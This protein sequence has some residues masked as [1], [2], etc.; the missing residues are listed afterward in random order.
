MAP[1]RTF[2]LAGATALVAVSA[3]SAAD[4]PPI[5]HKA[6]PIPVE[7]FGGWYLR[8]DVGMSNQQARSV[9][10]DFGSLAPPSSMNVISQGFDSAPFFGLGIGYQFN[11][12][13]RADITG[14]YRGKS[15]FRSYE[16]ANWAGGNR[17]LENNYG[18]KSEWVFL[19]N[20]YADL[21]TWWC[22][23]PFV[24]A[25]VGFSNNRISN[26]TDTSI[27]VDPADTVVGNG[28]NWA[29]DGSKWNFAWALYAGLAYKVTPGFTVE[30]AYR[31]LALGD[32]KTGAIHGYDGSYQGAGYSFKDVSSH[33]V[34]LGVRWN[35]YEPMVYAPPLMRKG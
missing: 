28:R 17:T 14:E 1:I 18:S 12:W 15:G 25:G 6:P 2:V 5:I 27:T 30:L 11:S 26:F 23:T 34:K 21:G 4:M 8:G 19:A 9:A 13:F 24:G 10:Y 3:A 35:L 7:E 22:I 32:F 33:D 31:Y 16:I 29:E 20:A